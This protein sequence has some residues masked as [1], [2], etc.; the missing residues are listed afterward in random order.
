MD[1]MNRT[2]REA[3]GYWR[4]FLPLA[5][6][7]LSATAEAGGRPDKTYGDW[8]GHIAGGVDFAQGDFGDVVDDGWSLRGGA[9]YWP[10][11]WPVGIQFEVAYSAHD[12]SSSAIRAINDAIEE[13]DPELGG[14]SG[15]DFDDWAFSVTGIWSLNG[16]NPDGL[17]LLA[18]IGIDRVEAKLTDVDLV[19]YPPICDP[20]WWWC[21]PGGV[22]P[23]TVVVASESSTE[24]SWHVGAGYS[25]RFNRV[26]LLYV[27]ARY[28]SVQ[29]DP[30]NSEI[31]PLTFGIRW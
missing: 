11:D 13:I 30:K 20:W 5:V 27:E 28:K 22:G 17:Y 21:S 25:F 1:A 16:A 24:L 23:G 10:S 18:G 3:A 7:V 9:T 19:Y 14:I 8:F 15:G 6:L 29:T 31:L 26:S 4:L 12:F 2:N